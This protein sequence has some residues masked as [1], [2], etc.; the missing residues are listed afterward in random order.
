MILR[1]HGDGIR[2]L[3]IEIQSGSYMPATIWEFQSK[4]DFWEYGQVELGANDG[5]KVTFESVSKLTTIAVGCH[6]S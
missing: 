1:Q 4:L 6:G 3:K 5:F 2:T